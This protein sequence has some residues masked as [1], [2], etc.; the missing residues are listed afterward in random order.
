MHWSF[1]KYINSS[2]SDRL[3]LL[4]CQESVCL[5]LILSNHNLPVSCPCKHRCIPEKVLVQ[6]A[7]PTITTRVFPQDNLR[8]EWRT[9]LG[10]YFPL[11]SKE[12]STQGS[13]FT[14]IDLHY[15][16]RKLWNATARQWR[17]MKLVP[18]PLLLKHQQSIQQWVCTFGTNVHGVQRA[19]CDLG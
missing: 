9:A 11:K 14:E 16:L 19:D 6:L 4:I 18:L 15:F 1:G 7:S 3:T 2:S 8:L 10:A 13:R 12:M 17:A 5:A